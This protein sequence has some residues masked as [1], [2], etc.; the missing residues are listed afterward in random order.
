MRHPIGLEKYTRMKTLYVATVVKTHIKEFHI[1][2]LKM[3]KSMEWDTSVA[4]KND[5]ENTEDC[6]IPYCDNYFDIHFERN[7]FHPR[8]I[9]AYKELK[10]II[11]SHSFDIIHCH[12][13]VGGALT[14]LAAAKARKK[15]TK[16]FYT[17]HGFHFY[18]GAP[19]INWLLYYPVERLLARLTDVLITINKEDFRTS[20]SFKAK[21]KEYIPGVGIDAEKFTNHEVDRAAL[22]RTLG[23]PDKSKVLLSVGELN[24]N[25]N[26]SIVI[27]ALK[28][29]PDCYYVIC[30]EGPLKGELQKLATNLKIEDRVI[31]AGYTTAVRD[32]YKMSDVFVFPSI[33]EGLP[34]A[35]M[36]AMASEIVCVAARNRGTKELLP[37]SKLLFNPGDKEVLERKLKYAIKENQD[38]EINA[39]S[40]NIKAY[41]LK[42]TLKKMKD[43]YLDESE[44]D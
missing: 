17:A 22:R 29:I 32:F 12:T 21:R 11:Q 30:G 19:I 39:N 4:A 9:K 13:P 34:V 16:V 26:H 28:N 1:P 37:N 38:D 6:D 8:N 20:Q 36:E 24:K 42:Y 25:K 35:L 5:F 10:G 14:R 23:I 44:K 18:K 40:K 43:L 33:R 27:K 41:D 15:G 31:L 2:Y 7:P 3:L